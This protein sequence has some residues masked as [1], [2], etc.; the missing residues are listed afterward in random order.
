MEIN[1]RESSSKRNF[2]YLHLL[3]SIPSIDV[4]IKTT[5]AHRIEEFGEFAEVVPPA[6]IRHSETHLAVRVIYR[7]ASD[8]VTF[9][10][11]AHQILKQTRVCSN[12]SIF[13][14]HS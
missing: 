8:T 12:R 1:F 7:L 13:N 9:R 5:D 11:T 2:H 14:I 10:P 3:R 4:S 6:G